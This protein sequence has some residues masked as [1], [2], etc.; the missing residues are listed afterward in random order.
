MEGARNEIRSKSELVRDALRE[1]TSRKQMVLMARKELAR[2]LQ[3]I[4]VDVFPRHQI[5]RD[6]S[7]LLVG[8]SISLF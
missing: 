7:A 1:Y 4:G 8:V 3:K 2:N 5:I 6:A